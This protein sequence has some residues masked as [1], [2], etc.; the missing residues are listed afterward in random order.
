M[1]SQVEVENEVD[2]KAPYLTEVCSFN[3]ETRDFPSQVASFE[4]STIESLEEACYSIRAAHA[5]TIIH[6]ISSM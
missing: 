5:G 3:V 6:G 1:H 2:Q 4:K